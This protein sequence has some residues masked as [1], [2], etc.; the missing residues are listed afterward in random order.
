M[1]PNTA[2]MMVSVVYSTW[3]FGSTVVV[4]PGVGVGPG[5]GGVP[6]VVSVAFARELL[7]GP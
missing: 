3:V 2:E 7:P 1:I 6:G 5:G 4:T